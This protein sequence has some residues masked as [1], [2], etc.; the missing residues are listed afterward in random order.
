MNV[1][2]SSDLFINS[3]STINISGDWLA[4]GN[5]ASFGGSVVSFVGSGV[6]L[7]SGVTDS[8][9]ATLDIALGAT[10]TLEQNIQISSNIDIS[11]ILNIESY[12]IN[13]TS[14]TTN[15]V[16]IYSGGN[17]TATS[18]FINVN[19]ITLESGSS[20]DIGTGTIQI[21]STWTNNGAS[22]N[23]NTGNYL[24]NPDA[25][26]YI[27]GNTTQF[28]YIEVATGQILYLNTNTDF[29]SLTLNG[30]LNVQSYTLSPITNSDISIPSGGGL[31]AT[32]GKIICDNFTFAR[33]C[34]P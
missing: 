7:I 24:F 1:E 30:F 31:W 2:N 12:T 15:N 16:V 29:N 20:F 9:F 27:N 18:G 33:F 22:V 13:Q 14:T 5:T 26:A 28:N 10:V 8:D 11:G 25:N 6:Q 32:T 21:N 17:L 3:S 19:L 4:D 34:F 23:P